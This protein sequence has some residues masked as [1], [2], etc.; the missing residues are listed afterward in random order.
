MDI[1]VFVWFDLSLFL[2]VLYL[3]TYGILSALVRNHPLI[4][5]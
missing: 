4:T 3:F 1:I 5:R 2:I